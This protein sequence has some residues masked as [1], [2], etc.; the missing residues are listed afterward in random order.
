MKVNVKGLVFVGFAAAILSGAAKADDSQIVTSKAF[1]EATYQ[2]LSNLTTQG[3]ATDNI[4]ST[5]NAADAKYPSEKAVATAIAAT[6]SNANG[7]QTAST[8]DFQVG[9]ASGAWK[10]IKPDS[11]ISFADGTGDDAGKALVTINATTDTTLATENAGK[12]PTAGA[13][14]TYVNNTANAK[15]SSSSTISD[16]STTTAPNESAVYTALSGKQPNLT[17]TATQVTLGNATY[18][19]IVSS[20]ANVDNDTHADTIPTTG[21]VAGAISAAITAESLGKYEQSV[22][23]VT[24]LSG[25]STDTQY[26]SA[27]LVYDQLALKQDKQLGAAKVDNA[28]S[29]DKGKLVV[30][31]ASGQIDKDTAHITSSVTSGSGDVVT[32]GA[33]YTY[34]TG[35]PASTIPNGS[36]CTASNPCALVATGTNTFAWV[37]MAQ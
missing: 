20:S 5:D 1:T 3:S 16:S 28:D 7:R 14:K 37:P 27:K 33:V 4:L 10:Q 35:L 19:D 34:V 32:S 17:G 8:L 23:K 9:G 15:V 30:I 13:V 2:K 31:N 18:K 29:T 6:T 24:S 26:P 12:L 11:Y 36:N 22:N 21:A 25:S